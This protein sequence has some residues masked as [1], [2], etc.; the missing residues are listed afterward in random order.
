MIKSGTTCT[1]RRFMTYSLLQAPSPPFTTTSR[2]AGGSRRSDGLSP[3]Q[4][5]AL[6][7]L[8]ASCHV[9]LAYALLQVREVRETVADMAPMFV[10]L[11]VPGP[12][13][14]TPP[15]TTTP[16][17]V[18]PL[19]A[20]EAKLA[21][22]VPSSTAPPPEPAPQPAPVHAPAVVPLAATPA[23]APSKTLPPSA[24]QYLDAPTLVYPRASRRAG[25]AGR[26]VLR[27]YIDEAGL[28]RQVQ[29]NQSSGFP[30]LD[31]AATAAV[32]TAR[33]KPYSDN[34]QP[35]AGWA[36]VPLTFALEK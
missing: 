11:V 14:V 24:V 28:P 18:K 30:R 1:R 19:I 7:A 16:P 32:Q 9:A 2:R 31:E 35:T 6:V 4:R 13:A 5:R 23:P 34:G 36:L 10:S 29:V 21:D 8:V 3:A 26:V 15:K 33:F 20:A 25:E 17:V 22:A 27:V 12:P